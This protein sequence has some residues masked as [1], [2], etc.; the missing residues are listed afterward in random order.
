MDME[1]SPRSRMSDLMLPDVV[2]ALTPLEDKYFELGV[3]LEIKPEC[4]KRIESDHLSMSRR[5]LETVVLWQNNV[6]SSEC[7]WST[8]A[9]AVERIGGHDQLAERLR[10]RDHG[11][12]QVTKC[13]KRRF[14]VADGMLL[15]SNG[16]QADDK[17]YS[18]STSNSPSGSE[19]E[20]FFD[21]TSG[22]GCGKCSLYKVCA[23]KCPHPADKD[24]PILRRKRL[25]T[26]TRNRCLVEEDD[27]IEDYEKKTS[28]IRIEF[29]KFVTI[30][31]RS[32]KDRGV[33]IHELTLF[34]QT[35]FPV[36]KAVSDELDG[37]TCVEQVFKIVV[38]Q[39]CSWFDYDLM[40]EIVDFFGNSDDKKQTKEYETRFRKYAEERLPKGKQHIDIGDGAKRGGKQLVV[41]IDKEWDK[42]SFDDISRVRAS[43][44]SILGVRRRDLYLAD[45]REGCIALTFM[46]TE[47]Q[48][49]RLFPKMSSTNFTS[50][51]LSSYFTASQI[52][53]LKDEG[54]ILL[55][56]GEL[57]LQTTA[58]EEEPALQ[59]SGVSYTQRTA[60]LCIIKGAL[61][62]KSNCPPTF[63]NS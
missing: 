46:I 13:K 56:C 54:V 7:R 17:G 57:N 8:L 16:Q 30:I 20:C 9:Y 44:A 60:M 12:E 18:S 21:I 6:N 37:A 22:C 59:S 25:H 32:F 3:Q 23:D 36:L 27:A 35:S 52:K 51:K 1:L 24:V 40:K 45:I 48:A 62:R 19:T 58:E 41:K 47:E 39:A 11:I 29:G 28:G 5:L 34:L 55:T 50:S 33:G 53:M 2:Q 15:Q 38:K 26:T 61:K 14:N 4:L 63:L 10:E 42:V 31:S 49:E 43:F